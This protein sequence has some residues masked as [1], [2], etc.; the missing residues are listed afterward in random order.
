VNA[1]TIELATYIPA[2]SL[3]SIDDTV[4]SFQARS[5]RTTPPIL[6]TSPPPLAQGSPLEDLKTADAAPSHGEVLPDVSL[7]WQMPVLTCKGVFSSIAFYEFAKI[8]RS[9]SWPTYLAGRLITAILLPATNNCDRPTMKKHIISYI[10]K[11]LVYTGRFPPKSS[12]DER[13][14]EQALLVPGL[15]LLDSKKRKRRDEDV[16]SPHTVEYD[17]PRLYRVDYHGPDGVTRTMYA[18]QRTNKDTMP[19]FTFDAA[20]HQEAFTALQLTWFD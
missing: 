19:R 1:G 4:P 7:S 20:Y 18:L 11:Q 13:K 17:I 15:R 16:A 14:Y 3:L 10:E 9:P 5:R 12:W 8:W 2:H 6:S